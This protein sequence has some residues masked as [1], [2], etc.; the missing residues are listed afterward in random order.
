L[1]NFLDYILPVIYLF[2]GVGVVLKFRNKVSSTFAAGFI[3]F[4]IGLKVMCGLLYTWVM[5]RYIPSATADINLF[6]GDG[7][8]MFHAFRQNPGNFP[9]YLRQ[10]FLI[11]DFDITRTDSDFIRTVFEGIKFI[12]FL[13]NFLSGG[14]LFTNVLLFNLIAAFLFLRC[15]AWMVV[16]WQDIWTGAWIFIFPS[17]FF[18]TSVILK[19]GIELCLIAALLPALDRFINKRSFWQVPGLLLLF[20]LLF[21]FKYLIAATF[22]GALVLYSLF[23]RYPN[24]KLLISAAGV[25]IAISLFFGLRNLHPR[26]NFPHI[27]IERRI[28]FSDL[29]ANSALKMRTLT[30]DIISF[31][32]ALPEA[33]RNVLF[34]PLPGEEGKVFYNLFAIELLLFWAIICWMGFRSYRSGH[35][36]PQPVTLAI[37][38]FSLANLLIIGFTITNTGAIIRYR[39]IFMPGIGLLFWQCGSRMLFSRFEHIILRIK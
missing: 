14:R 5:L 36:D 32:K 12:H 13:L 37:F 39:S 11:S 10:Q 4:F 30:P 23:S 2:I 9:N 6:F 34:R 19:E 7:L 27:I 24:R 18:F 22:C 38:L 35:W 17:A 21:F 16:K 3:A 15:W 8:E 25:F 33:I 20:S 1:N 26:L 31:T 28:E 29:E